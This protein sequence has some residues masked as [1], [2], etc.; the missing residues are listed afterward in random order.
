MLTTS[1]RVLFAIAFC[2]IARP[3]R[4]ESR[5]GRRHRVADLERPSL[6][7]RPVLHDLQRLVATVDA[8]AAVERPALDVHVEARHVVAR[9]HLFVG[10]GDCVHVL[11]GIGDLGA[12]LVGAPAAERR[13]HVTAEGPQGRD[14]GEVAAVGD[15]IASAAVPGER[16]RALRQRLEEC[17]GEVLRARLLGGR[18]EAVGRPRLEV[19]RVDVSR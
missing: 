19:R 16:A 18:R 7:R 12:A 9:D 17:Q 15:W 13:D 14:V 5:R 11:A 1:T 4:L 3:D 6:R 8:V 2:R 10:S